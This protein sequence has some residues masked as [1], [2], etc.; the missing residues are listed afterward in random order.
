VRIL[1]EGHEFLQ[2]TEHNAHNIESTE[3]TH[4]PHIKFNIV[5]HDSA[6][7]KKKHMPSQVLWFIF[8]LQIKKRICH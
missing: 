7:L 3:A 1:H 4:S 8:N 2:S 6:N 5:V